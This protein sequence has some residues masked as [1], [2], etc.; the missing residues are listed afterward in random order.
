MKHW[1]MG[2]LIGLL[3]AALSFYLGYAMLNGTI[4]MWKATILVYVVAIP[5]CVLGIYYIRRKDSGFVSFRD[6]FLMCLVIII[7]GMFSSLIANGIYLTNID[8]QEQDRMMDII[9]E[10]QLA[11]IE[12][13]EIDEL[14][15]EDQLRVQMKGMFEINATT[16]ASS[17]FSVFIISIFGVI[18]SMI[19]RRERPL[20]G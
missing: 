10:N 5:F 4:G 9:V 1:K 11:M 20:I 6:A 13:L 3:Y 18:V 15:L 17:M 19:M 12:N 8:E 7:T 16:I 2:I 14:E